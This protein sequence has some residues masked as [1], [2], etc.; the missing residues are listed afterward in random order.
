MNT[1]NK[2]EIIELAKLLERESPYWFSYDAYYKLAEIAIRG[3]YRMKK[4][5]N[6][7]HKK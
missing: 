6:V 7:D 5:F 2:K 4:C 3:A 1:E